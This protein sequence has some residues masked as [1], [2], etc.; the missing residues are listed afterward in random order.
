MQPGTGKR[1]TAHVGPPVSFWH[2]W[3][4]FAH[5]QLLSLSCWCFTFYFKMVVLLLVCWINLL[6]QTPFLSFI[7]AF[8]RPV[9]WSH[10]HFCSICSLFV[11]HF[12][13]LRNFLSLLCWWYPV[14]NVF[15]SKWRPCDSLVGVWFSKWK[16]R[17]EAITVSQLL[18]WL[19]P[20]LLKIFFY[21]FTV[22]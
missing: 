20:Y 4:C 21:L 2:S 3:P 15:S 13:H 11:K 5:A 12:N 6:I 10:C 16:P 19:V 1:S 9:F 17:F 8:H 18:N 22:F 7:L 14:V